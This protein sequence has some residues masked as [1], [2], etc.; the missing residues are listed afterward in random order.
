M[1]RLAPA[2]FSLM[3]RVLG[4]GAADD[5]QIRPQHA[6]A[7]HRVDVLG[8]GADRGDQPARPVDA[9]ALQHVLAAGVRLDAERAV[10]DR[11]LHALRRCARSTTYG[12]ALAPELLRD[13]AADAAVAADDEVIADRFEHTFVAAPLQPLGKPAFDDDGG[14]QGERVERRADAAEQQHDG[15]HL[16]RRDDRCDLAVP[17]RRHAR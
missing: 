11:R 1:T 14:E 9:D 12:I 5:E 8:V 6:R 15:E 17:D 2:R 3:R 16:A 7:Q 10:L 4:L 13:D